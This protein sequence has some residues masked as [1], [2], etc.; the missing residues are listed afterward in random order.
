[1]EQVKVT[2]KY[3]DFEAENYRTVDGKYV[4][5]ILIDGHTDPKVC[6]GLSASMYFIAYAIRDT[7]LKDDDFKFTDNPGA[8]KFVL[9]KYSR[10]TEILLRTFVKVVEE[11][12]KYYPDTILIE[13]WNYL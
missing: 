5:E 7:L 9:Y 11:M 6:H 12:Q 10:D 1:M 4:R 8:T 3:G 2:I 13:R